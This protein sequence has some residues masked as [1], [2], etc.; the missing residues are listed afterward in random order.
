[1][2]E[3]QPETVKDNDPVVIYVLLRKDLDWPTGAL[4]NQVGHACTKVAW[5]AREDPVAIEFMTEASAQM[6]QYTM[7]AKN[8]QE[9]RKV[10][11]K[12]VA[13]NI[14]FHL[15]VEQPEDVPSCLATRPR[16]RSQV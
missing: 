8:E 6:T 16:R 5:E 15:W 10:E 2:G 3:P 9:L 1:M 4:M 13:A 14:P 11:S 7:G 12:L